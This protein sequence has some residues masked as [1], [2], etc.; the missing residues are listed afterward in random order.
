MRDS[1]STWLHDFSP[2]VETYVVKE[3]VASQRDVTIIF[4]GISYC[5]SLYAIYMKSSSLLSYFSKILATWRKFGSS[6][7]S[8]SCRVAG[9]TK[10]GSSSH[11]FSQKMG[12]TRS[13]FLSFCMIIQNDRKHDR[14]N[15]VFCMTWSIIPPAWWMNENPVSNGRSLHCMLHDMTVWTLFTQIS[16]SLQYLRIVNMFLS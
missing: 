11:S 4:T 8:F 12:F 6:S 7:H 14:V 13:F 9:P 16:P 15:P 2:I 10:F 5:T 1:A 3:R